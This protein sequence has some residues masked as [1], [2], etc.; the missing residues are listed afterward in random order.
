MIITRNN[1][2]VTLE[3]NNDEI[4]TYDYMNNLS[5]LLFKEHIENL[6]INRKRQQEE[7]LK[8]EL[9][10]NMSRGQLKSELEGRNR[11]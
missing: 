7:D 4:E 2:I 10:K 5:S 6:F 3:L 9:T 1:N 11:G 8:V